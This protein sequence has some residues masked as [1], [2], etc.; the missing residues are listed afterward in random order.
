MGRSQRVDCFPARL[1]ELRVRA[2]LTQEGLARLADMTGSAVAKLEQGNRAPSLAIAHKLALALGISLDALVEEAE[3]A[4]QAKKLG[5]TPKPK[6]AAP[7]VEPDSGKPL[8][9]KPR[10]VEQAESKPAEE[11]KKP[12]KGK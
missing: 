1:A 12:R 3:A 9:G 4:P 10:K 5:P 8:K 6:K 11:P 7:L 2:G